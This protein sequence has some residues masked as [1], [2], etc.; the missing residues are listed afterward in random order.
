MTSTSRWDE[1]PRLTWPEALED[2]EGQAFWIS[3]HK[4]TAGGTMGETGTRQQDSRSPRTGRP[5]FDL[6]VSKLRRPLVRPGT[7]R[8]PQLVERLRRHA[9][10]RRPRCDRLAMSSEHHLGGLTRMQVVMEE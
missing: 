9:V 8:R 6:V 1:T 2:P 3:D 7:V 10:R 4:E 5:A